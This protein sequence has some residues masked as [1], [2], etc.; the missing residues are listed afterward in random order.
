MS[1]LM[2]IST[3]LA[4]NGAPVLRTTLLGLVW[5][6]DPQ[7]ESDAATVAAVESLLLSGRVQ[8]TGNFRDV[9]VEQIVSTGA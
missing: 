6:L 3:G 4:E 8:L 1:D 7:A 9:P 2:G 5:G